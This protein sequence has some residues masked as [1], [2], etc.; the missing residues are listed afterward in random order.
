MLAIPWSLKLASHLECIKYHEC[1]EI[2]VSGCTLLLLFIPSSQVKKKKGRTHLP[3]F[4]V[5]AEFMFFKSF[6]K[7]IS[8][9][10]FKL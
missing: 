10:N 6:E 7:I 9:F 4:F 1:S 8:E 5:L 2:S 3:N